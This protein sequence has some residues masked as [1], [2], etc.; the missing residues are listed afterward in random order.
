MCE[1]E[2]EPLVFFEPELTCNMQTK[3]AA[4]SEEAAG[5]KQTWHF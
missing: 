2:D 3:S 1:I 4:A 5:W